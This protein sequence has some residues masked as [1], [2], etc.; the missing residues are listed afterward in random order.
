MW[1]A[2]LII[3]LIIIIFKSIFDIKARKAVEIERDELVQALSNRQEKISELN[4]KVES[5]EN[6]NSQLSDI[7]NELTEEN[8]IFKESREEY[9]LKLKK[10][11]NNILTQLAYAK[12]WAEV[13]KNTLY[14][15][16]RENK[17][18][19]KTMALVQKSEERNYEKKQTQKSK[20]TTKK[21][22]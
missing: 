17:I 11:K 5:L 9:R 6:T 2:I 3:G 8:K 10:F 18:P 13:R 21:T 16:C 22:S 12:K 7:V 1:Y 4:S 19:K 20:Q 14:R 15:I